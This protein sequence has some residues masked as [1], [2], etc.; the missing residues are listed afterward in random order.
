MISCQNRRMF[1]CRRLSIKLKKLAQYVCA[2][3]AWLQNENYQK[4][5]WIVKQGNSIIYRYVRHHRRFNKLNL[6]ANSETKNLLQWVNKQTVLILKYNLIEVIW[7]NERRCRWSRISTGACQLLIF[8]P[9][10]YC[11]CSHDVVTID[12]L[13]TY[14]HCWSPWSSGNAP[15]RFLVTRAFVAIDR[16]FRLVGAIYRDFCIRSLRRRVRK[17]RIHGLFNTLRTSV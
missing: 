1:V 13:F 17:F 15:T 4:S 16:L 11:P 12:V 2:Q 6:A 3:Q 7:S 10:T 8:I 5:R 9:V 14:G